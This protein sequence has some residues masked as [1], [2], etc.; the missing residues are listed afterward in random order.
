[1]GCTGSKPSLLL[2]GSSHHNHHHHHHTNGNGT[3]NSPQKGFILFNSKT[4]DYLKANE[5]D[6]KEK[7]K[8]RCKGKLN[9][10]A[11]TGKSSLLNVKRNLLAANTSATLPVSN[12][13]GTG[14][15][16][17]AI[18]SA[19]DYVLK[20]AINDFDIENFKSSNQLSMKQIRKD[21][22]KKYSST[23]GSR[24]SA[25]RLLPNSSSAQHS[26]DTLGA[27]KTGTLQSGAPPTTYSASYYKS[28]LNTAIDEFGLF[29][30]E[31][32]IN[33]N[34]FEKKMSASDA[35]QTSP[36]DDDSSKKPDLVNANDTVII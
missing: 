22:M 3:I 31:N 29:I 30:Q 2:S 33:I 7:L 20:Y 9:V 11:A 14:A 5:S 8:S 23:S 27:A 19:V 1:M 36:A 15:D 10:G 21:I 18:E 17:A 35:N 32:F 34:E 28:A 12:G 16:V 26:S 25:S 13:G 24:L 4:I 6:I